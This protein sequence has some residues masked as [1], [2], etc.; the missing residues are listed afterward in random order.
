MMQL[1]V[2]GY[3]IEEAKRQWECVRKRQHASKQSADREA[4]RLNALRS[5]EIEAKSYHCPYCY[6]WHV[7]RDRVGASK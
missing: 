6:Y 7:G 2:V 1:F 3:S 4:Q 5:S